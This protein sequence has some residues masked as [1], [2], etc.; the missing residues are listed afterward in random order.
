MRCVCL[1]EESQEDDSALSEEVSVLKSV[2]VAQNLNTCYF[3]EKEILPGKVTDK[4]C[5]KAV[6]NALHCVL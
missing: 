6:L 3:E 1:E 5:K 2:F 4:T